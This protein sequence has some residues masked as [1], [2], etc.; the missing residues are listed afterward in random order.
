MN[1]G[2][3]E[4]DSSVCALLLI[5]NRDTCAG[6]REHRRGEHETFA[7]E[8]GEIDPCF[9]FFFHRAGPLKSHGQNS[10]VNKRMASVIY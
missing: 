5:F 7:A 1:I 10:F 2:P 9:E 4:P 3:A 8:H 6:E